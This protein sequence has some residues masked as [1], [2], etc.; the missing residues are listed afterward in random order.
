MPKTVSGARARLLFLEFGVLDGDSIRHWAGLNANPGSR[1]V[2]FDSFEGIPAAW[3][4]REPVISIA[5]G[6]F[7]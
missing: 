3:R 7:R 4:E 5:L 2:G 1:F 6:R